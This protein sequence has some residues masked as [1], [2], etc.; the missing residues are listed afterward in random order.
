MELYI[1]PERPKYNPTNGRFLKGHTPAN[2]GKKWSEWMSKR[3]Q[4]RSMKGWKNI[5]IHRCRGNAEWIAKN[6]RV[7]VV[8]VLDDGTFRVFPMIGTAGEWV[9]GNRG[10]VHRCCE[11]NAK[12]HVNR[13]TGR[14]N[15]DHR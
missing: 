1:P 11:Y 15:T 8:A 12:R 3:G 9:G 7:Q 14:I 4:K 6:H 5:E 10:N 2:K 13:K